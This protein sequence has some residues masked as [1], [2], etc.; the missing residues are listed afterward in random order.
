MSDADRAR[1]R[2]PRRTIV[3][4]SLSMSATRLLVA[5]VDYFKDVCFAEGA[6]MQMMRMTFRL[7]WPTDLLVE[8]LARFGGRGRGMM[9]VRSLLKLTR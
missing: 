6:R 9:D 7:P 8:R 2:T 3:C 5:V 4:M 1:G